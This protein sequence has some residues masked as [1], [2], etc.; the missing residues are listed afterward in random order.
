MKHWLSLLALVVLALPAQAQEVEVT[1]PPV[2]LEGAPFEVIVRGE[3]LDTARAY[4]VRIGEESAALVYDAEGDAFVAEDVRLAEGG[5]ATVEVVQGGAVVAQAETRAIA[6]WLSILPPLLAIGMALLFRRVLPALFLGVWLGA[7]IAYGLTFAGLWQGLLDAFGVYVLEALGDPG[8]A[9]IVLFS[10]MIGGMV[11]V[12][13]KNGGMHGIVQ[14]VVRWASDAKRGQV[15]TGVL[16]IVIFFDDYAN[17]LIVGNT[18]RPVT[19]KLRISREK[20]AYLVDSTAAPVASLALVTTWIGFEV[21]L[22]NEALDTLPALQDLSGY[23]VFLESILYR[24]YPW[25]ALFFVFA[26]AFTDREFG[27][28]LKAERR[29]R[30]GGGVLHP[31]A[32]VDETAAGG[33]TLA[34]KAGKPQRAMNAVLPV[35]VLV[36]GTLFFLY[37]TGIEAA[38]QMFA[39]GEIEE[40]TLRT[41]IGEADSYLS[42]M[43]ASLLSAVTAIVLS[44]GQRIL[45]LEESV[46]AWYEGLKF[47]LFAMLVL[48]LAWA[49][50]ETTEVLHTAEFL[51]AALSEALPPGLVPAIIF[52]L[53]AA[54]A[55]A[56]GTSWGTMGILMPLVVPLT[57]QVMQ[58]DRIADPA[59]Y[60]LLYNAVSCV[61]AGAVWGDHCSPISDTTILSSMASGCDH[62]AHVNTQL[63][64]ALTV[65]LVAVALGTIPTGFGFPWWISML[66]S[67]GL[68]IAILR[69]YGKPLDVEEAP[70]EEPERQAARVA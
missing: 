61:L 48:V 40:V 53:A 69:F 15:A 25:L 45:T 30:S 2:V 37:T 52:V 24:F 49:L 58:A 22:I 46:E 50:A 60:Y 9:A 41:I 23:G 67:A 59:H 62:I 20:L 35:C 65:G 29:A 33:E 39:A 54:I 51:G 1:V 8:H 11:G 5:A 42:L 66:V 47:M 36:F 26:I 55:F 68:L 28:M 27:P 19:D 21:G 43:W 16:G 31:D 44:V 32:N 7:W 6:G 10:L 56:T 17:T 64:Y 38:R 3:A 12:I 34:P 14:W 18:M 4:A 63:P 13:S 70:A 57:W